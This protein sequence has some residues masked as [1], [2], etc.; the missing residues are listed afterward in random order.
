[1]HTS[2]A[3][4]LPMGMVS[5]MI[6]NVIFDIGNVLMDFDW[7]GYM[8]SMY[9]ENAALIQSVNKAIWSNGCWQ[10]MDRGEM[11]GEAA[12]EAAISNAPSL[13]IFGDAFAHVIA[14]LIKILVGGCWRF[15]AE[16]F[17]SG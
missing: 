3:K 13:E 15:G 8:R 2:L 9:G 11:D 5:D 1:M 16:S 10:A 7:M 6:R 17:P 4:L 14:Y 12:T